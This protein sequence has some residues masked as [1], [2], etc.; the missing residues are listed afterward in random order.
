[1]PVLAKRVPRGLGGWKFAINLIG[2][3]TLTG[4]NGMNNVIEI[5]MK[6]MRQKIKTSDYEWLTK[7]TGDPIIIY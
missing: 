5:N 1:M 2:Q 7:P 3:T 6:N 4:R